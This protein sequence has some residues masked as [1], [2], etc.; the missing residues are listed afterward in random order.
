MMTNLPIKDVSPIKGNVSE[1]V[2]ILQ[3]RISLLH[4]VELGYTN[5]GY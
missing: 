1:S 2:V 3:A 5:L 4:S